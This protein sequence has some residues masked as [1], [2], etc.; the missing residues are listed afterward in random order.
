MAPVSNDCVYATL[1]MNDE[2]LPGAMVLGWSLR[3]KGAVS[4]KLVVLVTV[5]A[6][7]ASTITELKVRRVQAHPIVEHA[8]NMWA[9]C[10]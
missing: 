9:D 7:S 8:A 5:D 1:L 4:R 2:Y 6:L 3:D 10:V